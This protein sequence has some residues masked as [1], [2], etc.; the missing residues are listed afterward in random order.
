M[1]SPAKMAETLTE[2][3]LQ[4]T[5]NPVPITLGEGVT[6]FNC[7]FCDTVSKNTV[8]TA[9]CQSAIIRSIVFLL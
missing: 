5:A 2:T 3:S 4:R 7:Y 6:H 8:F 9:A 1:P